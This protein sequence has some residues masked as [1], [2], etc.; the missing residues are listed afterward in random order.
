MISFI[1][2]NL[3][4]IH[5]FHSK[6]C[7]IVFPQSFRSFSSLDISPSNVM[8]NA[9]IQTIYTETLNVPHQGRLEVRCPFNLVVTPVNQKDF[10][11]L[12]KAFFTIY[13]KR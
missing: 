8:R 10:P 13:G 11:R 1:R 9:E 2:A 6:W 5:H 4:P 12:D 3:L 7:S